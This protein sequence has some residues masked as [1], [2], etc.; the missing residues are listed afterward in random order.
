[1]LG[2]LVPIFLLLCF[3]GS[4]FAREIPQYNGGQS[5]DTRVVGMECHKKNRT[6]EIGYFTAY[7]IPFKLMDLWGTFDLK[8]KSED[9]ET[10]EYYEVVRRCNIGNDR[11]VVRLR[12]DGAAG[13]GDGVACGTLTGARAR[14]YRNGVMIL[15]VL[16]EEC[17]AEEVITR[18]KFVSGSDKPEITR[19]PDQEFIFGEQQ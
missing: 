6:L 13:W 7:N 19:T 16:F 17:G 15:D 1:M 8:Q 10:V 12:A 14:V 11:F 5:D 3:W 9:G 18:A 4:S 2:R